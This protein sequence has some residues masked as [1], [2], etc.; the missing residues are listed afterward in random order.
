M[1]HKIYISDDKWIDWIDFDPSCPQSYAI[2]HLMH[3]TVYFWEALEV[4]CIAECC[5]IQAFSFQE[6]IIRS[7]LERFDRIML[8]QQL[9]TVLVQIKALKQD[10]VLYSR[11]NQYMHRDFLASLIEY[12]LK[13]VSLSQDIS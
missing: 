11:W 1:S 2:D 7:E 9:T 12:I 3:E 10:V 13:V 5:G 6:D 8:H 4:I